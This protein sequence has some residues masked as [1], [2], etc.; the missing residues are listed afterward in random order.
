MTRFTRILPATLALLA[1]FALPVRAAVDI[2]TVT[3]PGGI[4]AWLVQ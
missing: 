3:S 4:T 2:Q 1:L